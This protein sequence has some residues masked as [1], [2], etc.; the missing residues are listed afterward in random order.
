MFPFGTTVKVYS[1]TRDRHGDR[2]RTLAGEIPGCAFAPDSSV[3]D[4]DQRSQVTI[5][6]SLYV[7]PTQ[8]PVN[9]QS[10][11]DFDGHTWQLTGDPDWWRHPWTDWTP[12]GVLHIQ[13]VREGSTETTSGEA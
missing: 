9:G 4:N 11:L 5:T 2:T 7:P 8:V 1:T 6:A 13:R 12:G 3:E 10:E